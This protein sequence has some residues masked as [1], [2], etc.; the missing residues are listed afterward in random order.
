MF[1]SGS[2]SLKNQEFKYCVAIVAFWLLMVISTLISRP[3]VPVDE[4]RYL[5]VAWEMWLNHNF[6]VPHLNGEPYSHKPPLLFWLINAGWWLFGVNETW[7]RLLPA[8]FQLGSILLTAVIA[9]QLWPGRPDIMRHS[10]L[11]LMAAM[12]W[13]IYTTAVMFDYLVVFFVMCAAMGVIHVWKN[14]AWIS[15]WL[16]AGVA[17]GLGILAKGPVVL[18]YVV[19]LALLAPWWMEEK[20]GSWLKWYISLALTIALG[21]SIALAWVLPAAASGGEQYA[22]QIL[23]SQTAERL[24]HSFAHEKPIWWYVAIGPLLLMPWIIWPTLWR[25]QITLYKKPIDAGVRFAIALLL[26]QFIL[27]SLISGKQL[28]YLLPLFP[29]LAL[30]FSRSLFREDFTLNITQRLQHPLIP[31]LVIALAG[32]TLLVLSWSTDLR[33][34]YEW[35]SGISPAWGVFLL[36]VAAAGYFMRQRSLQH[37]VAVMSG[38]AIAICLVFYLSVIPTLAPILDLQKASQYVATL[39]ANNIPVAHISRY[40]GQYHF[41]GRLHQPLQSLIYKKDAVNWAKQNPQGRIIAYYYKNERPGFERT[42]P[43][44]HQPYRGGH[45][46]IWHSETLL[47]VPEVLQLAHSN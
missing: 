34:R 37:A 10:P 14:N 7:P 25:A 11:I 28:Q 31:A 35:Y 13:A 4:T 40:S 30:L 46:A 36:A 39:Q 23:W 42:I 44:Y 26:P 2:D 45:M 24:V 1:G 41:L 17:I 22:G 3:V 38:S 12:F 19:P 27:L 15:G 8:L 18:V 43:G 32:I 20:S 9:K 33:M 16:L 47:T 21:G 29:P 6:L 5:A